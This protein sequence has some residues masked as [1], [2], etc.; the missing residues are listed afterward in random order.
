MRKSYTQE[1]R[2]FFS[3]PLFMMKRKENKWVMEIHWTKYAD[4][5]LSQKKKAGW[6]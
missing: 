5:L 6:K 3:L 2:S 1:Q 4:W